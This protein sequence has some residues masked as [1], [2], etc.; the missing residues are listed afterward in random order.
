MIPIHSD[1][2]VWAIL[3][4]IFCCLVGGIIAIVKSAQSNSLYNS[5][6]LARDNDVRNTLF[7]QSEEK[8][9]S[10]NTW[11]IISVIVGLSGVLVYILT[12]G[13]IGAGA[14]GAINI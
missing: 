10:A 12:F 9:R 3:V 1:K 14:L 6:I 5:A 11:I 4:T 2:M 13:I 8:N 7:A